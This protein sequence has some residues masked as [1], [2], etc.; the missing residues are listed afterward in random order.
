M[1]YVVIRHLEVEECQA[2]AAVI[3]GTPAVRTGTCRPKPCPCLWGLKM[4]CSTKLE[5]QSEQT[6]VWMPVCLPAHPQSRLL[7]VENMIVGNVM[8]GNKG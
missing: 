4:C 8:A 1:V 3:V 5:L 7:E 6:S 2:A